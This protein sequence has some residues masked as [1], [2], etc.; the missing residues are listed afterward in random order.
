LWGLG[1]QGDVERPL[2][3]GARVLPW[4]CPESS[5]SLSHSLSKIDSLSLSLSINSQ[6]FL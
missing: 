3:G 4:L 6:S 5:S 2:D 1:H